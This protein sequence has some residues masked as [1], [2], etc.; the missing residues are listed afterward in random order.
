MG[1]RRARAVARDCTDIVIAWQIM[2]ILIVFLLLI[3][4]AQAGEQSG[5]ASYYSAHQKLACGSGHFNP[6][7]LTA[8]H[9][10][11][12][13]G[14]IVNVLNKRNGKSVSVTIN[15][16]GPFV[17][18]RII[19]LSLEAAKRIDMIRAGQVPVVISW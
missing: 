12:P 14:T 17:R 3:G 16:R 7:K 4:S 6:K 15:D 8:A 9:R 1:R 19:D 5:L 18:G 2:K 13:C 11:L 10:T